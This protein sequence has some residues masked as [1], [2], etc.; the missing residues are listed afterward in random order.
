MID[1]NIL[2]INNIDGKIYR[3][4]LITITFFNTIKFTHARTHACMHTQLFYSPLGFCPGLP[5]WADTRR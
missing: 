2:T 5:G 3:T 4:S 1:Y